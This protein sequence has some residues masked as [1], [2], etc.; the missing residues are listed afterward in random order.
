MIAPEL[1]AGAFFYNT[2]R[3][4]KGGAAQSPETCSDLLRRHDP[5][6]TQVVLSTPTQRLSE[7]P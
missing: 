2:C 4:P 1:E 3:V 7:E 6:N 5:A